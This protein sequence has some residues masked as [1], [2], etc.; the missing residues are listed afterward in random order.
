VPRTPLCDLLG[1]E[2]PIL[3]AGFALPAG[4]E[5][6]AAV[7]NAGGL[8]VIGGTGQPASVA[9][10]RVRRA[11]ELTVRP[12]GVNVILAEHLTVG[13]PRPETIAA[14]LAER[15]A[16]LILFWGDP[17]PYVDAAHRVGT[18][19]IVQVGDVAEARAAAAAGVD[20]VIAQGFESGGH[21]KGTVALSTILPAV[22]EAV[23]PLPV[24][25]SGGIADGR[26]L[27][28]AIALGAQGASMGTR[29]VAS[30]E[31]WSPRA[32]KERIVASDAED[33]VYARDLFHVN[34]PDAPH[35]VIRNRLVAE[36]EA[37]GHPAPG[38]KPGEGTTIGKNRR[39]DGT[40]ADVPRYGA[41]MP[42][43]A[44]EG[45]L[46][47]ASLWAGQ[48]VDLIHDIKPAGEIVREI[49]RDADAALAAAAGR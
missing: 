30:E 23:A 34:W 8:G 11:R 40:T 42:S 10:E 43:G 19:V 2:H 37:A 32:Y 21:V 12:F 27:A 20:A 15:I 22:V 6:A 4:P 1:I 31:C 14:Y 17:R 3:N 25:A 9:R 33:T 44:F 38:A 13:T 45:D 16:V 41:S 28:G 26:G 46:E 49:A 24:L 39:A 35:R 18:K 5:L 48:S 7:S 29:F 47:L 36:W